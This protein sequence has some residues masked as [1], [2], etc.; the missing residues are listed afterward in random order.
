VRR[1]RS[2]GPFKILYRLLLN[3]PLLRPHGP[4]TRTRGR[5]YAL[6]KTAWMVMMLSVDIMF[7]R[8]KDMP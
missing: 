8:L 4:A 7:S 6:V 5:T 3:G 2:N 1:G